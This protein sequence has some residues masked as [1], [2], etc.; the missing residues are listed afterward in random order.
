MAEHAAGND[1]TGGALKFVDRDAFGP[2][3]YDA[4]VTAWARDGLEP[5]TLPGLPSDQ[6]F[7]RRGA[8]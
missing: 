4:T 6:V 8:A 7:F 1:V 3:K 2:G 5:Y